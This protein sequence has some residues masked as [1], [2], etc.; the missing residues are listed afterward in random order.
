MSN[1][2]HYSVEC[3]CI[4]CSTE[5]AMY[6]NIHQQGKNNLSV[7]LVPFECKRCGKYIA[8]TSQKIPDYLRYKISGYVREIN[9]EETKVDDEFI[10]KIKLISDKTTEDKLFLLLKQL[11]FSS[12]EFNIKKDPSIISL[13]Y[14]K[15]EDEIN[16]LIEYSE[17][18]VYIKRPDNNSKIFRLTVKGQIYLDSIPK[19]ESDLCF[20]A[21]SFDENMKKAYETAIKKG[22]LDAGYR[23]QRVDE[24]PHNEGIMDKIVSLIKKSRFII[25]DLTHQKNGVYYE[26]G[27]AKGIG[28]DVI[29]T[30][31]KEDF[32]NIHFDVSHINILK[33]EKDKLEE[34]HESL[35]YR[36]EASIGSGKMKIF[37]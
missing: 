4:I 31:E 37:D 28:L 33:W 30:C 9:S 27:F 17:S 22:V 29:F 15:S 10:N 7:P 21:M 14:A 8:N 25:A 34:F 24:N 12:K 13:C 26:A 16:A 6:D 5:V 11:S 20:I 32:K 2:F 18:Q 3:P 35:K 19:K 36:I 23:C 1:K